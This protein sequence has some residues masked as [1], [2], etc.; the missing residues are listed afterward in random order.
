MY[1]NYFL[2]ICKSAYKDWLGWANNEIITERKDNQ[3]EESEEKSVIEKLNWEAAGLWE[4]KIIKGN[5][6]EIVYY[7][8]AHKYLVCVH[9]SLCLWGKDRKWGRGKERRQIKSKGTEDG[10]GER[11]WVDCLKQGV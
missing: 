4:S 1:F 2:N 5:V 11:D 8:D 7:K 10:V 9:V 6:I 3:T